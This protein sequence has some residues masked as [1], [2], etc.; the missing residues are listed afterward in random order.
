ME[1]VKCLEGH[2]SGVMSVSRMI[3]VTWFLFV[4]LFSCIAAWSTFFGTG[5]PENVEEMF[6]FVTISSGIFAGNYV[7]REGVKTIG[8]KD[9]YD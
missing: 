6:S 7:G 3:L 2:N 5:L 1:I 9:Q 4:V 8:K